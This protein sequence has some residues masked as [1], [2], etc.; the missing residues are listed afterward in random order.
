MEPVSKLFYDN[1]I[2]SLITVAQVN[3]TGLNKIFIFIK[4]CDV[5]T[6]EQMQF[7]RKM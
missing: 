2:S 3:N 6:K 4:H 5:K 1:S 7:K